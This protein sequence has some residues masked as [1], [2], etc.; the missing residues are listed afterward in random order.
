MD[1]IIG[2]DVSSS[3]IKIALI[4]ETGKIIFEYQSFYSIFDDGDFGKKIELD[5]IWI[6]IINGIKYLI[7]SSKIN[8]SNII[9]IS[10]DTMRMSFI[11]LDENNEP[12]YAGPNIDARGSESQWIIDNK[13]EG[14][15]GEQKLFNITARSPPLLFGL[16]RLLWFKEENEEIFKKINSFI[17]FDDWIQYKLTGELFTDECMASETQVFDINQRKWSEEILN[18]FDLDINIF[19]KVIKSGTVVGS[20][21]NEISNILGL[22]SN[23]KVIKSGPDTQ[24]SLLGM[25]CVSEYSLGITLGSSTPMMLVIN[26]PV[27][28]QNRN[29]WTSCNILDNSWVIEANVGMTGKIYDWYKKNILEGVSEN[30]DVLINQYLTE[31]EPGANS[32]FAFMGPQLMNFKEQTNI[33]PSVFIFPSQ[34]TISNLISN[35]A[36]FARA[37]IEN[38]GFGIYENYMGLKDLIKPNNIEKIY[39]GGGMAKSNQ[40]LQIICDILGH[41]ILVPEVVD[42]TYMGLLISSLVALKK[43]SRYGDAINNLIKLRTIKFN[44]EN[45]NK[46]LKIYNQWKNIKQKID[47]I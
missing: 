19:P 23:T 4:E 44:S 24:T 45:N 30:L 5:E 16:A 43:Y 40:I 25:G 17:S 42:S 12:L 1:Y 35:R 38:I 32:T 11:A 41:D 27:I 18:C 39:L 46:Y 6:K 36:T 31:T 20:I 2:I 3:K 7:S 13:F 15:E 37:I 47:K 21:K 28:D 26:K 9:A 29:F 8:P 34:S 14:E 10:S 22:N 33:K